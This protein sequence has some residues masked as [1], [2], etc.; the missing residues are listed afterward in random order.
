MGLQS[1]SCFPRA[2]I[3]YHCS[4]QKSFYAGQAHPEWNAGRMFS[5]V[6]I[7]GLDCRLL[8]LDTRRLFYCDYRIFIFSFAF[9]F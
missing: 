5:V 4:I 1:V 8:G 6:S 3:L 7:G 9:Y 2:L